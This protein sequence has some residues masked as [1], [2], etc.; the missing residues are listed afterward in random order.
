MKQAAIVALACILSATAEEADTDLDSEETARQLAN[1]N[2]PLASLTLKSQ[3]THWQGNLPG[4]SGVNSGTL[5]FQPNFPFPLSSGDTLF[6]RPAFSYVLNQPVVDSLQHV[7]T[8]YGFADMG[9]DL[10]YGRTT[11]SGYLF[12][13]G[14]LSGMP[15]GSGRLSS[16]TWTV[17]PEVLV[18]K[19]SKEYVIGIFPSQQWDVSGPKDT[20]LTSIQPLL[21]YL[22]GGGFVIGSSGAITY[23]WESEQWTVPIQLILSKTLK[24]GKM[25][26]KIALEANYYVEKSDALGQEWMVGLNITPVVPNVLATMFGS[27]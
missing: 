2:T 1:P 6:C 16:D 23:N 18:G 7:D 17:G 3:F 25:P 11:K 12:A 13:A 5:L 19:L 20:N 10:A 8:E 15:I 27:N 26:I 22:P 9:M 4:A 21:S 14:L 24:I